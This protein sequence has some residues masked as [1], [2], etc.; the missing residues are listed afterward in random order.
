MKWNNMKGKILGN[1]VLA[2]YE[3]QETYIEDLWRRDMKS[4]CD[5][6]EFRGDLTAWPG[7]KSGFGGL[8]VGEWRA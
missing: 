8:G 5:V 6:F 1:E 2:E 3:I 7:I 4:F